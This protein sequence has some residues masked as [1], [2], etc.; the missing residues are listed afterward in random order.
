MQ[1][2]NHLFCTQKLPP[3]TSRKST[4]LTTRSITLHITTMSTAV[5]KFGNNIC[6]YRNFRLQ[7]PK[8]PTFRQLNYASAAFAQLT[9]VSNMHNH[10]W[11]T[12][13]NCSLK[14][15]QG[16]T[17]NIRSGAPEPTLDQ[18]LVPDNPLNIRL[19]RGPR[20]LDIG[21]FRGE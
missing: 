8:S 12:F 1:K 4:F 14:K 18:Q 2:K 5:V 19:V 9:D 7:L 17:K 11:G 20:A 6:L 16:K 13:L 3:S 21:G 15:I 10:V